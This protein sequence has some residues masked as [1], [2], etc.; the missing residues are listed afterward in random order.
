M[1]NILFLVFS[2]FFN[3]ARHTE[4]D[5]EQ[6]VWVDGGLIRR[7]R[8]VWVVDVGVLVGGI[9][10]WRLLEVEGSS[11]AVIGQVQRGE[12]GAKRIRAVVEARDS[13]AQVEVVH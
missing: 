10:R 12:A 1:K 5:V 8:V 11:L 3:A 9:R 4:V 2:I 13:A 7:G 6:A